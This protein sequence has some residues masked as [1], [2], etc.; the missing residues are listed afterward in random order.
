MAGER[1]GETRRCKSV[2]SGAETEHAA[3]WR[4]LGGIRSAARALLSFVIHR[5]DRFEMKFIITRAMRERMLEKMERHLRPD[6]VAGAGGHYPIVSL[7]YD[8]PARDCYWENIN[9]AESRRKLR[10]RV[11]GSSAGPVPPTCFAEIKHKVDG[12]NVK[13]RACLS[14]EEALTVAVRPIR[15]TARITGGAPHDR[16]NP[17][18]RARARLRPLLLHPL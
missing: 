3:A 1:S 15:P 14:L 2:C 9:G 5:L 11:Y 7:Y 17:K 10:V 4:R 16:R 6:E 13:R 12:R 18:A 8:T